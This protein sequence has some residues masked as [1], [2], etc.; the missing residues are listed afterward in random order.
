MK[1]FI[2]QESAKLKTRAAFC[3][4]SLR[5]CLKLSAASNTES[6]AW[7]PNGLS[8]R[9]MTVLATGNG[10]RE[11]LAFMIVLGSGPLP[12]TPPTEIVGRFSPKV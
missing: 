1:L 4:V 5:S 10:E 7:A 8:P 11:G 2:T 9:H 6:W 12:P 3:L